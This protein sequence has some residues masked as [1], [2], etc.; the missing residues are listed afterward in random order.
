MPKTNF[1]GKAAANFGK[2]NHYKIEKHIYLKSQIKFDGDFIANEI[3]ENIH[4]HFIRE[5]F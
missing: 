5:H 1:Q 4:L 3:D 2:N